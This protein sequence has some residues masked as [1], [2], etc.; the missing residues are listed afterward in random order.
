MSKPQSRA[1]RMAEQIQR[2]LAEIVRQELKD[3]RVGMLTFTDVEVAQDYAHAKVFYTQLGGADQLA[4]T[5][6]ALERAA[7]FL[8][9]QLAH[10]LRT[11]TVPQLHFVYDASVEQGM[12]LSRLI[13]EALAEDQ[14]QAKD[15][16]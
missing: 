16:S 1:R 14:A 2:E 6:E 9:S 13:D 10:R 8:R 4:S 3:P 7:G 15:K 5:A 12:R 11:R